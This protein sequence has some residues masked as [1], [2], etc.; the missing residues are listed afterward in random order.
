MISLRDDFKKMAKLMTLCK[1]V[2][3]GW[4]KFILSN[5]LKELQICKKGG[6][7]TKISTALKDVC[8]HN[9]LSAAN[10]F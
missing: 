2:E 5:S 10:V 7:Q 9:D 1:K 6:S 8:V 4:V 3:G